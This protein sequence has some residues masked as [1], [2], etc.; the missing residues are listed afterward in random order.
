LRSIAVITGTRAD[1]GLLKPIIKLIDEDP[2]L[3]LRLY[4]TGMHLEARFGRTINEI[5]GDGFKVRKTVDIFVHDDS[6]KGVAR[7]TGL[8]TM[9]FAELFTAERPDIVVVLGDR[10]EIFGAVSACTVL[11]IPVAHIHGGELTEGVMDDTFRHGITKMSKLHF[12]AAE[13]YRRRV[14]Q[15]GEE[16]SKVFYTGSPSIDAAFSVEPMTKEELESDL[17]CSF[18]DVNIM[19]TFHPVISDDATPEQQF[20]NVLEVL[21]DTDT[22][23][24]FTYANADVGGNAINEAIQ[25]YVSE[26]SERAI[27]VKSLGH[28]RYISV[29]RIFDGLVG[30]SSSALIEAGGMKTGAVN[31]GNRQ[32]GRVRGQNVIDCGNSVDEIREAVAMLL[33]ESFQEALESSESMYGDGKSAEK[34]VEVLKNADLKDINIKTFYDLE[35]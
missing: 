6:P 22:F 29:M 35:R 15:L 21:D 9:G 5:T 7:S 2:D 25:K 24:L 18:S 26:N 28:R 10:F 19:V 16:P 1:Y 30:N 31:I 4:A 13:E 32:K 14:I 23:L 27:A 11:G 12:T 17:G 33:S 20:K 34:I 3:E 8:A